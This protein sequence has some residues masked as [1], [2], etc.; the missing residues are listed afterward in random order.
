MPAP[1]CDEAGHEGLSRAS[2]VDGLGMIEYKNSGLTVLGLNSGSLR[3]ALRKAL[4]LIIGRLPRLILRALHDRKD[5]V[6]PWR[7]GNA[8]LYITPLGQL[9]QSP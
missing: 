1:Q 9:V 2:S 8:Y 5:P 4:N 3:A 6:H 7:S